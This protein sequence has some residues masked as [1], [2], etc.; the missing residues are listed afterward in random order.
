MIACDETPAALR[1]LREGTVQAL[2]TQQPFEQ[3]YTAVRLAF[4][5]I[6]G[7][8]LP[9]GGHIYMRNE[10]RIAQNL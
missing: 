7:G 4:S 9:D 10:I 2:V 6:E 3:G 5:L 8:A 1:G